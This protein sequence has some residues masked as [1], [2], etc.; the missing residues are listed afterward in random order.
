MFAW[1]GG[2][3]WRVQRGYRSQGN[4][5]GIAL[6][7]PLTTVTVAAGVCEL[8]KLYALNSAVRC[9]AIMSQLSYK[10]IFNVYVS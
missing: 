8:I 10:S 9:T 6:L 7:V 1:G 4:F 3:A 2:R 5:Q